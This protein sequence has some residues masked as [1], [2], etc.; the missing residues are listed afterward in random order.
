MPTVRNPH[1]NVTTL[2]YPNRLEVLYSYGT[3]VAADIPGVG[4]VQ[5][6]T[7]YS[8]TT[9]KH[10]N[11]WAGYKPRKLDSNEFNRLIQKTGD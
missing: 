4:I 6:D 8:T 9:S 1:P 11:Q 3:P 7:H 2:T 10:I 5:T